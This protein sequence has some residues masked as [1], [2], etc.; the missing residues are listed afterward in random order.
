MNYEVDYTRG[1]GNVIR[2]VERKAVADDDVVGLQKFLDMVK[3]TNWRN[4]TFN[5]IKL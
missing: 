1:G 5:Y 2:Y 3:A 4:V